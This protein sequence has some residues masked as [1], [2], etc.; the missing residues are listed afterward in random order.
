MTKSSSCL[1]EGEG[2]NLCLPL[3]LGNADLNPCCCP[4][5]PS[6]IVFDEEPDEE[7]EEDVVDLANHVPGLFIALPFDLDGWE[8]RTSRCCI[9]H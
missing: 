6:V 8:S 7:L 2:D 4:N 9:I 3:E 1:G 5:D